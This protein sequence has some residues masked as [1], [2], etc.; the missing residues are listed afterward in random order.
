M[1]KKMRSHRRA[2]DGVV[3]PAK[4]SGLYTFAKL[5]TPSARTKVASRCYIDRA[6]T[7]PVS[8]GEFPRRQFIH[9]FYD[10]PWKRLRTY[11]K[12][13]LGKEGN[14][15]GANTSQHLI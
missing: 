3:R 11:A 1:N 10:R 14:G 12:V 5:T 4:S 13:S 2:A 8:G 15:L 9:S 7:P 6:P